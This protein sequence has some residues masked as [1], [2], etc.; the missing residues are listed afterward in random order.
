MAVKLVNTYHLS[1]ILHAK[2][3]FVSHV[4]NTNSKKHI[5]GQHQKKKENDQKQTL[6]YVVLITKNSIIRC[7]QKNLTCRSQTV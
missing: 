3:V 7:L 2:P 6:G 4:G 1:I 5:S